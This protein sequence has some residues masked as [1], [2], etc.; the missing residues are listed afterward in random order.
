[1]S[2]TPCF[3]DEPHPMHEWAIE[4]DLF[5]CPGDPAQ[6]PGPVLPYGAVFYRNC[7]GDVFLRW[8]ELEPS[9][10]ALI[11]WYLQSLDGWIAE[12]CPRGTTY[13]VT[14]LRNVGGEVCVFDVRLE[15]PDPPAPLDGLEL[16]EVDPDRPP[17]GA[18]AFH[19]VRYDDVSGVSG[20]GIVANGAQMPDGTIALRWCVPDLP[21]TWNLFDSLE[22]LLRL[23]G[24][25]GRTVVKWCDGHD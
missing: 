20:T 19:L 8:P 1:M 13:D 2:P 14:E 17:A 15:L 4:T 12:N 24:H 23:N 6:V 7:D 25:K 3:K 22:D 9:A 18:R 5:L 11:S 16:A 21:S 10:G